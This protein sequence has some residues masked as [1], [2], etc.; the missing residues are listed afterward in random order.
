MA[1]NK[2]YANS[3]PFFIRGLGVSG[4]WCAQKGLGTNPPWIPRGTCT[5]FI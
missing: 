4:F 1:M 2:L 5:D 3:T